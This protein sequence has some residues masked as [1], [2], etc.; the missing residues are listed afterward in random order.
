M[1]GALQFLNLLLVAIVLTTTLGHALEHPGKLRLSK[2]EY[3]STQQI[4]YPGFTYA[5]V[6]EP[7]SILAVSLQAWF[8]R[9][10]S[11]LFWSSLAA[12][13]LLIAAH[14]VYWFVTHPINSV[15]L[16]KIELKGGGKTFFEINK[17]GGATDWP[18]LRDRWEYSHLA[19]AACVLIAFILLAAIATNPLP[20]SLV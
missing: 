13:L 20:M 1:I 14:A 17:G 7:V 15:W 16:K 9:E 11:G 18:L 8:L 3:L 12:A 5:G 4:Y 2:E 6:A 10:T 19:R